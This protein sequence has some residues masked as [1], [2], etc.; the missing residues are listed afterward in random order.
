MSYSGKKG[1]ITKP[2]PGVR[3]DP[4][5]PLSRGLVG[6]WLFNEGAGSVLYDISGGG[7]HGTLTNMEPPTDWVG[8]LHGGGLYFDGANDYVDTNL[9]VDLTLFSIAFWFKTTETSDNTRFI[10]RFSEGGA[11]DPYVLI[12]YETNYQGIKASLKDDDGDTRTIDGSTDINDDVWRHCVF[13]LAPGGVGTIYINGV[14][15]GTA[16]GAALGT[17]SANGENFFLGAY[18]SK[19]TAGAFITVTFDDVRFYTRALSVQE[20]Q[21]LYHDPYCNLLRIPIRR[22]WGIAPPRIPR[23]PAAYNTLAIY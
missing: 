20:I 6:C 9:T 13:T 2:K 14:L 17:F 3:I 22:Y 1:W 16:I 19:G 12:S 10:G 4:L 18:N 21:Q 11:N 5:H 15:D 7:H 8:S 23:P